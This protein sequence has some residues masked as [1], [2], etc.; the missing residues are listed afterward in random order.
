MQSANLGKCSAKQVIDLNMRVP[1][2]TLDVVGV[3]RHEISKDGI[4]A[5]SAEPKARENIQRTLVRT[6]SRRLG[7]N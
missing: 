2:P 4:L 3:G 6:M 7:S 1:K 5:R